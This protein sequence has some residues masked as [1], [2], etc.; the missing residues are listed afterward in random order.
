V[1]ESAIAEDDV[2]VADAGSAQVLTGSVNQVGVHVD[3]GDMPAFNDQE[4]DQRVLQPMPAP[5]SST[6]CQG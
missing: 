3:R 4:R 2:D 5:I 1:S 6:R